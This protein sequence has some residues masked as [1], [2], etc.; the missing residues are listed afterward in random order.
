MRDRGEAR[1]HRVEKE[2]W[3][4]EAGGGG[5]G[6]GA[7]RSARASCLLR[8]R[9]VRPQPRGAS[10]DSPRSGSGRRGALAA[11]R[12]WPR[13]RL[14]PRAPWRWALALLT[15]GGAGLCHAGPQP[16]HPARPGARNK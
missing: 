11:R 12:M 16:M 8:P 13:T 10:L 2:K 15:L 6:A 4:L 3:E 9:P 1:A 5:R 7:P 14:W